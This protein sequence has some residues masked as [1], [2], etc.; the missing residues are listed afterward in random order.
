M[1]RLGGGDLAVRGHDEG[2]ALRAPM[3]DLLPAGVLATGRRFADGEV[4]GL[5][6]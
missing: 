5:G 6:G 2:R 4:I 1:A 3:V